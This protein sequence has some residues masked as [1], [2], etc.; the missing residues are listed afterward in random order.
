MVR[1]VMKV[2]KQVIISE[3]RSSDCMGCHSHSMTLLRFTYNPR[4]NVY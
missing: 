2:R 1:R 3:I 4:E